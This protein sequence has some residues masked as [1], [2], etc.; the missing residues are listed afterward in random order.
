M[1]SHF[2]LKL[3]LRRQ[4]ENPIH[5]VR[6]LLAL[7]DAW[8]IDLPIG[9][10]SLQLVL[11]EAVRVKKHIEA[12][13]QV[14]VGYVVWKPARFPSLPETVSIPHRWMLHGP[15]E[16]I[17]GIDELEV[18]REFQRM[19]TIV[20]EIDPM[21]HSLLIRRPSLWRSQ[22]IQ[23][24]IQAARLAVHLSPQCAKGRPMRTMSFE[25]SD[26]K[27]FERHEQLLTALLDLRFDKEVSR[28]G[29][30]S[31]L[32]AYQEDDHW[33]LVVDLDG[34]LLPFKKSRIR[35]SEL[36]NSP[37]PGNRLIIIEN[38]TSQH[39]LPQL[40]G[41]VAV[42]GAGF[43]LSWTSGNWLKSKEVAYWGDID[44]WGLRFLAKAR[45][46][47]PHLKALLM[48]SEIYDE[49]SE[50]AV[51]EPIIAGP[52]SPCG[53]IV[54]EQELYGRLVR[55]LR[56]RLEQ[57]YLPTE[58]IHETITRWASPSVNAQPSFN[59]QR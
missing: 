55:E 44:T 52:E 13:R 43:D 24:V 35:S 40:P 32:G 47:L 38:E 11:K 46:S 5:R 21:F 59:I 34:S 48:T 51:V 1:K 8:P 19:S 14:N 6:R 36:L 49:F 58:L 17:D 57:E 23:E 25:G 31:F 15:M 4:W 53:L 22:P 37:L 56:G 7:P 50:S 16:W 41:A 20:K 33:L 3:V 18:R 27:F 39:Q 26:T 28:I 45:M 10:P 54:S 29:F 2:D 42:L 12:W 30:K 9:R